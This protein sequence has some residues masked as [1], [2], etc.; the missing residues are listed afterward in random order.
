MSPMRPAPI[1][2]TSVPPAAA[3]A[4]QSTSASPFA[5]SSCPVTTV[6]CV[7]R[8]RW[9]TGTPAYAGAA[10]ALVMPGT[11]SNGTPAAAS[12]S[13]SSPPRPNTNGSPPLSRTTVRAGTA[14]LDEQRVDL[15]LVISTRPGRLADVDALGVG[16]REVD[17]RRVD[18][19]V[20]DDNVGARASTSAPAHR[21]QPGIARARRRRDRRSR[22]AL[23]SQPHR[24]V[25]CGANASRSSSSSRPPSSSSSRSRQLGADRRRIVPSRRGRAQRDAPVERRQQRLEL[26]ACHRRRRRASAPHGRLQPPPSAAR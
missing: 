25:V 12:A 10:M 3:S 9:V 1:R 18:E 23:A 24:H 26:D 6:K 11:T 21:E 5:G 16:R 22:P 8:P 4:S 7:D 17:E 14:A 20:V 15:V 13:A 2:I 19:P